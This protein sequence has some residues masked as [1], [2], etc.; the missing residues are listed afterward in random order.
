MIKSRMRWEGH[1]ACTEEPRTAYRDLAGRSEE[2]RPL[3][4]RR[5]RSE[6]TIKINLGEQDGRV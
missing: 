1:V 4:R 6:G 3:Q 2:M 5:H